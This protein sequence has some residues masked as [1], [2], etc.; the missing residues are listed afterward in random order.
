MSQPIPV[1][2]DSGSVLSYF[3][4][5]PSNNGQIMLLGYTGPKGQEPETEEQKQGAYD[6]TPG[7]NSSNPVVNVH[8]GS[9]QFS[10]WILRL[11]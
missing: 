10:N 2:D 8:D 1:R 4:Y 9:K 7:T 11:E 6:F 3:S 5:D